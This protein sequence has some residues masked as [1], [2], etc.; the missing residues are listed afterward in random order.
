MQRNVRNGVSLVAATAAAIAVCIPFIASTAAEDVVAK[1]ASFAQA[2]TGSHAVSSVRSVAGLF[3]A[4][5]Y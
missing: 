4:H 3:P 5:R 2:F 1:R